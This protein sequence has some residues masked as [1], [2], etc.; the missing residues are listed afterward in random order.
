M[1]SDGRA[2]TGP[3]DGCRDPSPYGRMRCVRMT[4]T[5][6]L[7]GTYPLAPHG[8]PNASTTS[9][10]VPEPTVAS[11]AL[12]GAVSGG[13]DEAGTGGPALR[14]AMSERAWRAARWEARAGP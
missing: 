14:E 13:E 7:L 9:S 8:F 1:G 4:R 12:G 3:E 5:G 6:G 10:F 11:D 2:G